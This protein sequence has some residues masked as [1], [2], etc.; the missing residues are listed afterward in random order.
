[1]IGYSSADLKFDK[2][3]QVTIIISDSDNQND[4]QMME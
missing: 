4:N 1:M 2:G 3:G